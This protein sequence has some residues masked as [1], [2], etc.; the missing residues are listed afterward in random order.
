LCTPL[1][2]DGGRNM[3]GAPRLAAQVERASR[4]RKK[5]TPLPSDGDRN[6][7]GASRL[8]CAGRAGR[9][10]PERKQSR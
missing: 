7:T 3:T 2:S 8:G 6:I 4:F 5:T 10:G 9:P 1:P